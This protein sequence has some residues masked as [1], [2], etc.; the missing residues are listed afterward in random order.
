MSWKP[1]DDYLELANRH[2]TSTF[3]WKRPYD[4][5]D[6]TTVFEMAKDVAALASAMGGTVAVGTV[7]GKGDKKGRIVALQSVANPGLFET[8]L[9]D[10]VRRRCRPL[11]VWRTKHIELDSAARKRDPWA[12]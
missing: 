10:A 4:L 2:E 5:N 12:R 8:K 1:T 9:G 3:D 11:P 7:E 6:P